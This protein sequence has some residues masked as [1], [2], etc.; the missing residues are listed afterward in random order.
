LCTSWKISA[1]SRAGNARRCAVAEAGRWRHSW[2]IP[3]PGTHLGDLMVG[4]CRI[5]QLV[6]GERHRLSTAKKAAADSTHQR[7]TIRMMITEVLRGEDGS[8]GVQDAE[9]QE[10]SR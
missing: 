2:Q 1:T 8:P 4:L 7:N 6:L 5:D 9:T 3:Q 10:S